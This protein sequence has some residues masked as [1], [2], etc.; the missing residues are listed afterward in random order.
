MLQSLVLPAATA[1]YL[2]FAGYALVWTTRRGTKP[3]WFFSLA[4]NS[5]AAVSVGFALAILFMHITGAIPGG[6]LTW[7]DGV[8]MTLE[9]LLGITAFLIAA[10]AGHS[11]WLA[12]VPCGVLG[13]LMIKLGIWQ[14]ADPLAAHASL[15]AGIVMWLVAGTQVLS[16][17][18][19]QFYPLGGV[20][21]LQLVAGVMILPWFLPIAWYGKIAAFFGI[22]WLTLIA[23]AIARAGAERVAKAA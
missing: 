11:V 8:L 3:A 16:A 12:A 20:L 13:A 7:P 14:L 1:V 5:V 17:P 6:G 21:T 18:R 23:G 9:L 15:Y 19:T 4:N 22:L 2:A 10:A